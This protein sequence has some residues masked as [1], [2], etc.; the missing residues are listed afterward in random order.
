MNEKILIHGQVQGG[1][2]KK[3]INIIKTEPY[4]KVLV[5]QNNK[6]IME[7]YKNRLEQENLKYYI[8]GEKKSFT[9]DVHVIILMNN[10]TRFTCF[11]KLTINNFILILDESD[12]A[13]L[14]KNVMGKFNN[15][16][17]IKTY[18]VTATPYNYP[19]D[20]FDKI[21]EIDT[22]P[23]YHGVNDLHVIVENDYVNAIYN[24]L[25]DSS[26]MMLINKYSLRKDMVLCA[27]LISKQFIQIP[28]VLLC[29]NLMYIGQNTIKL[30]EKS[31]SKIIDSLK[32]Y[33]H[34]IFVANR[35]SLRGISYVSSDYKRHLTHQFTKIRSNKTNFIQSLR[36]LGIYK[37]GNQLKLYI[38]NLYKY[39]NI[40]NY[41]DNFNN[42]F[43]IKLLPNYDDVLLADI[44][45]YD[46]I[47]IS[48]IPNY[49]EIVRSDIPPEYI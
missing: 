47:M 25:E 31:I 33:P 11:E 30:N 38:D 49:E 35:H 41:I 39:E 22:D 24:L 42:D 29:Y 15:E 6:L 16:Y 12:Q 14:N 21:I 4:Q 40:K 7:Q 28:V 46:E 17:I 43:I 3:I 8:V 10:K 44:Q 2:T 34:I 27:E 48:E 26:G 20:Y 23:N 13:I 37:K 5:I 9:T 45:K 18:H 1:K 32:Q 19:F 36:I